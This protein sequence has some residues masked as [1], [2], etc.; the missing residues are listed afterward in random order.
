MDI[1]I[2]STFRAL[3]EATPLDM[4]TQSLRE[5]PP[6]AP[7]PASAPRG[8]GWRRLLVI[9]GA[10]ALTIEGGHEMYLVFA[11]NGVTPLAVIMLALFLALFGWI[12]LSFTSALAGFV[13]LLAGT[14]LAGTVGNVLAAGVVTEATAL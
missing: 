5:S 8:M 4:P 1:L 2:A 6:R 12:A 11:A 3:P 13:A 14:G 7:R 9:G 10:V